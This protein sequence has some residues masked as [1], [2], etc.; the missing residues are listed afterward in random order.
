ML[1][2]V[3]GRIRK[4]RRLDSLMRRDIRTKFHDNRFKISSSVKVNI[5]T[6][7]EDAVLLSSIRGM[8]GVL[9]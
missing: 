5:S 4:V 6:N 2:L 7:W 3:M 8:Y 1:V 9:S